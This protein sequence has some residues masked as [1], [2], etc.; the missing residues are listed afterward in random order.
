MNFDERCAALRPDLHR[1]CTRMTGNPCDGEDIVQDALATA[2]ARKDELREAAALRSWLFRIAHTKCIDFLRARKR[3]EAIDVEDEEREV[4]MADDLDD[5][6]RVERALANLVTELPA[7]ERA[8]VVLKDVLDCSLEETAEITRSNVGAVKAAL[9]RGREKLRD[10]DAQRRDALPA[11]K[12]A[13]IEDY[14]SAFNRR[15]WDSVRALVAEDAKLDVVDR[16]SG[17][18][19]ELPYLANYGAL[20]MNW[21][22]EFAY[23]DGVE[24]VVHY[25][26]VDGQ[27]QP[28]SVV[29]I[30]VEGN[31]ISHVRDYLHIDYLL[32]FCD[33]S[34][35]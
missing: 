35:A 23:V 15:D 18:F 34:A 31:R 20:P 24:C 14:I 12:R 4:A 29:A 33:V 5:K 32:R 6:R 26:E 1:F 17:R 13:V 27:W 21:K 8:A 28:R 30:S 3:F 25:R 9:H 7:K 2:L 19:H 10:A 11:E 22:L 16:T